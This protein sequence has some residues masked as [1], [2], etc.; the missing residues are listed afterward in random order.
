VHHGPRAFEGRKMMHLAIRRNPDCLSESGVRNSLRRESPAWEC[1]LGDLL[2]RQGTRERARDQRAGHEAVR[3]WE[4]RRWCSYESA[5]V[6]GE[7]L[8]TVTRWWIAAVRRRAEPRAF[9]RRA[10]IHSA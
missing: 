6:G 10:A 8:R 5:S 9:W 4:R 1:R 3:S 2:H 7:G